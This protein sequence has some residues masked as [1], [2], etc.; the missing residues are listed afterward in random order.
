MFALLESR[1]LVHES[2]TLQNDLTED[3]EREANQ[4]FSKN[5]RNA[6]DTYKWS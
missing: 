4:A 5:L 6:V 3:L 2:S 1:E